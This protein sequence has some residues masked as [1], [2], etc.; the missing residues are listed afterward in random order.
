MKNLKWLLFVVLLAGL[1]LTLVACGGGS[2]TA[3]APEATKVV[4]A[5]TDTPVPLPP[6]STPLPPPTDTPLPESTEAPAGPAPTDEGGSLGAL[7]RPNNVDSFRSSMTLS[8]QGTMTD[9]TEVAESMM[10][11]VEYVRDP[12]AEHVTISGD[13]PGT[14]DMGLESGQAL[15]MYVVDNTMYMNLFG[16]WMQVPAEEGGLDADEMAFIT[17]EDMLTGLEDANYEGKTTYNGVKVKHY[18]FDEKSFALGEL[19]AG[20]EI[21]KASGNVYIAEEGNY[22]V[23][24]DMTMSGANVKVPTSETGEVLQNG[25]MDI[26]MDLT[27]INQPITI[28]VPPEALESGKPPEDIPVPENAEDLQVLAMMGMLTFQSVS[29]PEELADYYKA[30]MPNNGWTEVTVDTMAGMVSLVYSKGDR[31]ATFL[32]TADSDTGKTSVMVTVEGGD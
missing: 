24:M 9:G 27:D 12:L 26:T 14:E 18:T 17:T 32:I 31:T 22:V 4:Q 19:P 29:T 16:N 21:D 10:I 6:T 3:S 30:E 5:A 7:E 8:W 25:S 23:H 1:A 28:E 13:F 2:D 11:A 15:E 20:M